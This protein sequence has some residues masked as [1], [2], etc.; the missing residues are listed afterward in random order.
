MQEMDEVYRRYANTVYKYL[1]SLTGD[2]DLAD[3]LTQETFYQA[4]R[5]ANRF[6][7][8]SN[9]STWLCSIA[10]NCLAGYRRKH[11]PT[12][13]FTEESLASASGAAAEDDLLSGIRRVELMRKVHALPD[14]YREIIYLRVFGNMSFKE[15]GEVL[16]ISENTARVSYYRGKEKLRKD[17]EID[18]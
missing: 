3:E 2:A 17:V 9:V 7:G 5:S 16:G 4:V 15:I 8:D 11:P 1:M 6:R 12:E 14:N 18:G 10:K 13:E